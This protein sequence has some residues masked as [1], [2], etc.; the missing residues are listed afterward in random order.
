MKNGT[1]CGKK[2]QIQFE[3]DPSEGIP[4]KIYAFVNCAKCLDEMPKGI[5]PAKWA[6]LNVGYTPDG[7][8]IWCARHDINVDNITVRVTP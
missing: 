6:R 8:Q 7:I 1:L 4:S 2:S 5:S 3:H